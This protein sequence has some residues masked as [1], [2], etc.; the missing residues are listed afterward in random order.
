MFFGLLFSVIL[1]D[2]DSGRS[3]S[4]THTFKKLRFV[5]W[6]RHPRL[7]VELHIPG[8]GQRRG[9]QAGGKKKR[10]NL[11][12]QQGYYILLLL[13]LLPRLKRSQ[14]GCSRLVQ[15]GSLGRR[16]R[17]VIHHEFLSSSSSSFFL[18]ICP[19]HLSKTTQPCLP[20]SV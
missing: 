10:N 4:Y 19:P 3:S 2:Y 17:L 1:E 6:K 7:S 12:S 8:E 15:R 9:E 5:Y 16:R 18:L 20:G 13:L 14:K 11:L